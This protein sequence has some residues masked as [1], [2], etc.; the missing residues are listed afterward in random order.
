MTI[1]ETTRRTLHMKRAPVSPL[2]RAVLVGL[3]FGIVGI[4][5]AAVGILLM[6][7]QR[8]MRRSNMATLPVE[9]LSSAD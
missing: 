2:R 1:A 4:Y 9:L 5:L 3:V 7:H 8:S 6:I